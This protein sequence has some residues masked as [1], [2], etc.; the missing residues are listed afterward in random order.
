MNNNATLKKL[1]RNV[2]LAAR[3]LFTAQRGY[4]LIKAMFESSVTMSPGMIQHN[5]YRREIAQLRNKYRNAERKLN[6]Y[7]RSRKN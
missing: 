1:Q 4:E 7:I 6:A 3:N 2:G 5:V